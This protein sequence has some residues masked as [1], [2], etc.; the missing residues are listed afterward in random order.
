MK[1]KT[2]KTKL[3]QVCDAA[4]ADYSD[5]CSGF[6]RDVCASLS[7]IIGQGD[8]NS[9]VSFL[10]A[11]WDELDDGAAAK[12]AVDAG[13]F[14][15]A[16]LQASES[17]KVPKPTHGHVAVV[18]PGELYRKIYPKVYCGG[19]SVYG[20]SQGDKSVGEVWSQVD[21]DEVRYYQSKIAPK[22]LKTFAS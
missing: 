5:N 20:R 12:A 2:T 15:I 6:L 21:R 11:N 16:G 9:I 17:K 3:T 4:Y 19:M 14:V 22:G 18:V 7:I 1:T 8:A 10:Q 13:G